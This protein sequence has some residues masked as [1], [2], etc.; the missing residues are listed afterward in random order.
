MNKVDQE[1]TRL[2]GECKSTKP[3][4]EFAWTHDRY[5]NP[6]RKVCDACFEKV[7]AAIM[8]WV[9]DPGDAGERLDDDY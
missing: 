5:G 8:E 4:Y 2:C 9:F 7:Q 6:Y 1:E 3:A